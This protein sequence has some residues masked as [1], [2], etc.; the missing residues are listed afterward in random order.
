MLETVQ[1]S[2]AAAGKPSR[3]TVAVSGGAD[4]IALLRALNVLRGQEGFSLSA[5]HVDHGL[6]PASGQDARFVADMCAALG[7]PCRII[8]VQVAGTSENAAR[9]ARYDALKTACREG[10]SS[11]LALA[12]H[13]RDQAETMLLHLFRGSGVGGLAAMPQCSQ[14]VWPDGET[15]LL[16][17][18]FLDVPPDT[19]R[20]ALEQMGV[21]WRED[22]TNAQD[23]YSR[24]F[25]R[26][27]VLPTV[28]DR[29]PRAEEA[30]GRA[31][32]VLSDEALFFRREAEAF[33]GREE[34]ARLSGPCRWV[35]LSPLTLLHPALKRHVLRAACP[36]NMDWETTEKLLCLSPGEKMNLPENWRAACTREYLHFLPPEDQA[37][38]LPPGSLRVLPYEGKTGDGKRTQAVPREVYAG[39]ELRFSQP[40]DV[41]RPLGGPG[42]K[43][44]QD[45]WV[46]KKIPRP[47]RRHMPLLCLGNRVVWAV[48]AGAGEEARVRP[49]RD[50]V[51]LSYEGDLPLYL[52]APAQE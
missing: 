42:T 31:A 38:S 33:L 29:F 48:G 19:I 25:I 6:R 36:V 28:A 35:R 10:S 22:E 18:P 44:M 26:H 50:A 40:G 12:H 16:W 23:D 30:M 4:S 24:N 32:K 39:C 37:P 51:L 21:P 15:L 46:D 43:S 45:Y 2:W 3:V 27:R 47:F 13:L 9:E 34:N 7:V 17:R 11:V 1:D 14:R 52:P 49:G 41:I 5:A 20:R 8:S